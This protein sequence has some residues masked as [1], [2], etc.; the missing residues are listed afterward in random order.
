MEIVKFEIA[1]M[2]CDHCAAGIEKHLNTKEG[3]VSNKVSYP[4][5]KGEFIFDPEKISREE[6]RKTIDKE[7]Q[8]NVVDEI[9][10]E[11]KISILTHQ[12]ESQLSESVILQSVIFCP[13]CGHQKEETMPTD[14]C[15]FFY[16]CENCKTILKP[17]NNHCCVY[18]SYGTV[19]CP[20]I[21][22]ENKCC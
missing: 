3:L 10:E 16:E 17:L 20:P 22:Q 2:T 19:P 21:Q 14:S 8:Y 9:I 7:T 5:K 12:P 6:I 15:Q 13:V 18:C 1:G 11:D 4:D